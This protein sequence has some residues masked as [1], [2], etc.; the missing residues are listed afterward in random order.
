MDI[1]KVREFQ[2]AACEVLE[3]NQQMDEANTKAKLIR[4]F[5]ENVLDW[6]FS[7]D[8]ELEYSV[9]SGSGTN[10]VDYALIARESPD[11]FVEAKPESRRLKEKYKE[12]LSSYMITQNVNWGILTNGKKFQFLKREV[13]G[14]MVEV[15]SLKVV[16]HDNLDTQLK[17]LEALSKEAVESGSS[18]EI[19]ER[20]SKI[21]DS[22]HSLRDNKEDLANEISGFI[23]NEIGNIAV[24]TVEQESKEF[25]DDLQ[26]LLKN[27]AIIF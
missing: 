21:E 18:K 17:L 12:Q 13:N 25:I 5:I 11:I 24:Q 14:E 6:P 1:R 19:A 15:K 20:I 8:V 27:K 4:P 23:K 22:V 7:T 2:S 16:S 10:K 26:S 9:K 3:D